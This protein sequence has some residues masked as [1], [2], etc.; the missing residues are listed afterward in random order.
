MS[1]RVQVGR[2]SGRCLNSSHLPSQAHL[3]AVATRSPCV[4]VWGRS[5]SLLSP[6][7]AAA[8][9][10]P[11]S[12]LWSH[13]P[14]TAARA[15]LFQ[16]PRSAGLSQ[17]LIRTWKVFV[18]R[19]P[20]GILFFSFPAAALAGADPLANTRYPATS[21]SSTCRLIPSPSPFQN[22]TQKAP[23]KLSNTEPRNVHALLTS[24]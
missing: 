5:G 11:L 17:R 6:R 2:S 18:Q 13:L 12:L 16:V 22:T 23:P 4:L 20:I 14:A 8:Q 7:A 19:S 3:F 15:Q 24:A 21:P 1:S 10:R 9:P